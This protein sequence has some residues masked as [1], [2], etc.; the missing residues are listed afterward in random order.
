MN[1]NNI[2]I[3]NPNSHLNEQLLDEERVRFDRSPSPIPFGKQFKQANKKLI[4]QDLIDT[5]NRSRLRS[6]STTG[7]FKSPTNI[8]STTCSSSNSTPGLLSKRRAQSLAKQPI[9]S[10]P[11]YYLDNLGKSSNSNLSAIQDEAYF[12]YPLNRSSRNASSHSINLSTYRDA[13]PDKISFVEYAI[14]L[15][16]LLKGSVKEQLAWTF[17]LYDVEGDGKYFNLILNLND[18]NHSKY[19]ILVIQKFKIIILQVN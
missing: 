12:D 16:A 11:N 1:S 15:S 3:N 6:Q 14:S 18:Y 17:R 9:D 2:L 7:G 19:L 5:E 4:N 10:S 13:I 8:T